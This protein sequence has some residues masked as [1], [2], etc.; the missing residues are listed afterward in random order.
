MTTSKPAFL[1]AQ[2]VFERAIEWTT[3]WPP[4]DD[5]TADR[6]KELYFSRRW[7]SFDETEPAFDSAFARLHT[8][9]HGV[10]MVNGTV[11]LEC[12]LAAYGIGAGDEVIV[13]PLTWYA[14]A[15]APHYLGARPVF[16]DI[17]RDTLCIDPVKIESA[18][19][20]R[21]RAIIPVHVFGSAADMDRIML[22]AKK[23][24]LKVIED[25]AHVHGS[26]WNDQGIGS[27]GDVGSFS[28]QQ[29]KT[30]A[31]GEGGIC[32]TNDDEIADRLYRMK[33]IGYGAGE[34]QGKAQ[35]GPPTGLVCHN[36]RA[37]A[38]QALI[39]HEQL[40]TLEDRLDRYRT[41]V[42]YLEKR[43]TQTTKIRF[44]RRPHQVKRQGYY[45]WVMIFDDPSFADI[46]LATLEKAFSAEGL[47]LSRTWD[48]L[49]RFIL[50]NLKPDAF[51]THPCAVTES[52]ASRILALHHSLLGLEMP[53]LEKIADAIERVVTHIDEL[54][55]VAA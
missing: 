43:L 29:S 15:M 12:A 8:S 1:G 49:Y 28:F 51:H 35:S 25:C 20:D 7:S 50:F 13:P 38:F 23:H 30:M 42:D 26:L 41:A 46:P 4:V 21:T 33:H 3:L 36:Y 40:K 9:R 32:I 37:T 39:L 34:R 14:T 5:S 2:P 48:P 44:Q 45:L 55:R 11:T 54:R 16:V 24:G 31:S 53:V 18:I 6:L 10:F 17:Q 47:Q 27:I 52:V 22:I 19:T